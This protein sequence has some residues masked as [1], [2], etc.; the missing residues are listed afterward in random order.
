MTSELFELFKCL[1]NLK[2]CSQKNQ[3]LYDILP[4][5]YKVILY[6]IRGLYFE[7][8]DLLSKNKNKDSNFN[9]KKYNLKIIDIYN[10]LKKYDMDLFLK[11]LKA[12]LTIIK[13]L[14]FHKYQIDVKVIY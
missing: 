7:K 6:K 4:L 2:D 3:N 5:E 8:K 10:L 14:N 13:K 12:R 1:Y 9:Y 11:L